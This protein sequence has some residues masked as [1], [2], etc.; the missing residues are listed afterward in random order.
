MKLKEAL[1]GILTEKELEIVKTSYDIVNDIAIVEVD[2]ELVPKEKKIAEKIM[3][4][5]RNIKTV[6]K[7]KGIHEGSF[8]IQKMQHIM[9]EDKRETVYKEN[10]LSFKLNVEQV[11]FSP[12]LSTERKRIAEQVKPGEKVLVMFSGY[13]PYPLVILNEEP[14]VEKIVSVEINPKAI[15]YQKENIELNKSIARRMKEHKKGIGREQLVEMM[16]SKIRVYLG[17]VKDILPGMNEKFDRILMPLPKSAGNF[18]DVALEKAKRGTIVHF[19]DFLNK[20]DMPHKAI[21]KIEGACKESRK[22]FSVLG[23]NECGSQSPSKSRICVDFRI[24]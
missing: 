18:L 3:E 13:G 12:R 11:Y 23:W 6:L 1:K 16:R 4:L 5:H 8:R 14:N 24:L 15:E 20:M 17:D 21:E 10:G 22:K 19:Y 7:K 9:G 2:E